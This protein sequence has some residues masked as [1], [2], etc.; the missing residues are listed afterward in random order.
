[1]S[2]LGKAM[3][4]IAAAITVWCIVALIIGHIQ[5]PMDRLVGNFSP[6]GS[7]RIVPLIVLI[8]ASAVLASILWPHRR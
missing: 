2:A 6:K 1:M 8:A 7:G 5:T 3:M 4:L